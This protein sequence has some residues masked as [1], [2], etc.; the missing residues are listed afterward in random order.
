MGLSS[1]NRGDPSCDC[2]HF[3]FVAL[4]SGFNMESDKIRMRQLDLPSFDDDQTKFKC[5]LHH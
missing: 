4:D 5:L 2:R 3:C 1:V